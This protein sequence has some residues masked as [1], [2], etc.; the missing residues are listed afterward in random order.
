[1]SEITSLPS[2]DE[3]WYQRMDAFNIMHHRVMGPVHGP[4]SPVRTYVINWS[5]NG[6]FIHVEKV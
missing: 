3:T 6:T 4:M 2:M 1:M 5:V